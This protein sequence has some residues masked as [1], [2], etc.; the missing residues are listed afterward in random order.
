MLFRILLFSVTTFLVIRALVR[1]FRRSV[2]SSLPGPTHSSYLADALISDILLCY[3]SY[4]SL[5]VH[6]GNFKE[7]TRS[8]EITDAHIGWSAKYGT[9]FKIYGEMGVEML[10]ISDPKA[11]QYILNTSGYNF[12]K[13]LS[14]RIGFT[15]MLGPGIVSAEGTQHAR[16][17]KI[18][19]PAFSFGTLREFLPLFRQKASKLVN[20]LKEEIDFTTADPTVV[21][22]VPW[23]SRTTLDI[24][25]TASAEYDFEALDGV[26]NNK[27]AQVY[28]N[29]F[30]DAIYQMSDINIA[31]PY[32][33]SKIPS[34]FTS[35]LT[36]LPLQTMSRF[37]N[38]M[39]V[40]TEVAQEVVDKQ[41]HLYL[42]G[43]EGSKDL[44][45]LLVHAN[46]S[47]DPKTKVAKNEILAQFTYELRLYISARP[48]TK[49]RTFFLAGHETTAS[50]L[51]WA[52]FE[53]SKHPEWQKKLREEIAKT[54]SQASER[55]DME[56][57][58][59][60]FD[61]MS[62]LQAVM[63]ETLRAYPIVPYVLRQAGKDDCIPLSYPVPT[64][65][66]EMISDIPV[67]RGERVIISILAYNRLKSIWGEDADEWR[68]E[69]FLNGNGTHS[70]VNLGLIAN[71]A[72]FSSGIRGCIGWRFSLLE[73]QAI[74]IELL[75]NFEFS[76]SPGN[77]EIIRGSTGVM[78]PMVKGSTSARTQLPITL[79]PL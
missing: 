27:L 30:A 60:D 16:H 20:K 36:R 75:E 37:R 3:S 33:L 70:Q 43:K 42:H 24:I 22:L 35:I 39:K 47:E 77:V 26:Q 12:P 53:L 44:M 6:V 9:A 40:A 51:M 78:A 28:N 57:T 31:M 34:F 52:S 49:I 5:T 73:M 17:R 71:L 68:P 25:G 62:H 67:N 79:T 38:Y 54:R 63:K 7:L 15:I 29:I 45:S 66:G 74:L 1:H 4:I 14:N 64:V 56:L 8:P 13:P 48:N 11:I 65:N 10:F 58:I 18:L 69:R 21:D 2:I 59:A 72:T 19:N 76:P 55:G 61:S 41:T 32:I 46:L 50:A 23:L